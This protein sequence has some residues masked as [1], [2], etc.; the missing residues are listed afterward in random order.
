MAKKAKNTHRQSP[1]LQLLGQQMTQ[2][3]RV[4]QRMEGLFR[5]IV[6]TLDEE[7]LA[8]AS[9]RI[10]DLVLSFPDLRLTN[11]SAYPAYAKA[12]LSRL[13]L[14]SGP[15]TGFEEAMA[16]IYET[17]V[18][19]Q[20]ID[21]LRHELFAIAACVAEDC[22]DLLP[23]VA[24]AF[25]SLDPSS[26]SQSIFVEMVICASAI[27]TFI[28]NSLNERK[29]VSVD[30][31]S[32]LAA[33]PSDAL[34]AAVGEG[35]AYYYASIPG[36][37]LLLDRNRVLFDIERLAPCAHS[38]AHVHNGRA[39]LGLNALVDREYKALLSAEIERARQTSRHLYPPNSVA[40]VDMLTR[41]ALDAL[42]ELPP[43]VNPLL[44]AIFVQSWVRYLCEVS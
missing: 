31:S 9:E 20:V 41:R 26:S 16:R 23:T 11:L 37:L 3:R 21:R 10:D 1:Y 44:Q 32:W 4:E 34:I 18:T 28:C 5:R 27:E 36:I 33:E 25:L 14:E 24:V 7:A 19:P 22:S 29:S 8:C 30:V 43:Q 40:D 39:N 2:L 15:L 42:D 12:L 35:Q 6:H 38:P 13:D 17:C